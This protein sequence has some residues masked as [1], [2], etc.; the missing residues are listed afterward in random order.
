MTPSEVGLRWV[1][2][3]FT[4]QQ[5]THRIQ[6]LSPNCMS[7]PPTPNTAPR[8]KAGECGTYN[9]TYVWLRGLGFPR[10]LRIGRLVQWPSWE[11][12]SANS[13]FQNPCTQRDVRGRR[14]G[15]YRSGIRVAV[16]AV[17]STLPD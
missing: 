5:M 10:H 15:T 11:V 9:S 4:D 2:T 13:A 1:I 3:H 7:C 6:G 17:A 16:E 8:V 12:R 14:R